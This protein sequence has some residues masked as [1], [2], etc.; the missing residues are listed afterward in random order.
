MNNKHFLDLMVVT[1]SKYVP[2]KKFSA[3]RWF[4]AIAKRVQL[5]RKSLEF[6][7]IYIHL[8]LNLI[9]LSGDHRCFLYVSLT[10]LNYSIDFSV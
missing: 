6:G 1:D 4:Y 8:K 10:L 9:A 2:S 7:N 3:Y 5:Y